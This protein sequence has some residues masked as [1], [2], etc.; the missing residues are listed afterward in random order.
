MGAYQPVMR[1][2]AARFPDDVRAKRARA[3]LLAELALDPEQVDV[4]TLAEPGD[5]RAPQAVLAGQFDEDRV[6]VAR[7]LLE[8]LG[9]TLVLDM[10][11][12]GSNG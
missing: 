12:T 8:K 9:G 3:K 11:A 7:Q 1:V 6:I 4:Q 2:L 5:S 10:D